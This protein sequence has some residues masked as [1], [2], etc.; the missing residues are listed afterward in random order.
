MLISWKMWNGRNAHVFN[1]KQ[2]PPLVIF[3]EIKKEAKLCMTVWATPLSELM[4]EE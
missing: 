4:L 1:N 2:A 3:E